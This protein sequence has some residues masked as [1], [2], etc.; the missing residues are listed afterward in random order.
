VREA[1]KNKYKNERDRSSQ[2]ART[3][4]SLST[5][6]SVACV[7]FDRPLVPPPFELEDAPPYVAARALPKSL[8]NISAT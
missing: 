2:C 3:A 6:S 4:L 8:R 7:P 5:A 1:K